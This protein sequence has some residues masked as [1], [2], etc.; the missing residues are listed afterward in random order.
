MAGLYTARKG[1]R[2]WGIPL[3]LAMPKHAREQYSE[4]MPLSNGVHHAFCRLAEF[5]LSKENVFY[6]ICRKT[7]QSI[8]P[9]GDLPAAWRT[10]QTVSGSQDD[11]HAQYEL[12]L[13]LVEFDACQRNGLGVT[14]TI[15]W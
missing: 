5:L 8:C 9:H 4:S 2:K 1:E 10:S 12:I 14:A 7:A 13:K 15:T 6:L 11:S 3:Y